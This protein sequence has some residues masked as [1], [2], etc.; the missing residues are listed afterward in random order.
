MAVLYDSPG[1]C[2]GCGPTRTDFLIAGADF[3]HYTGIAHS[4]RLLVG[5]GMIVSFTVR[6]RSMADLDRPFAPLLQVNH[7][8]RIDLRASIE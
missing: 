7:H 6:M 4:S 8:A 1:C 5:F 3:G 2:G